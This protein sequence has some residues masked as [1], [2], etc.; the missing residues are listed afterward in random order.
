MVEHI[1][2]RVGV[3]EK[4]KAPELAQAIDLTAGEVDS[5]DSGYPARTLW[6]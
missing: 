4:R 5:F 3:G 2:Y 6:T 1:E